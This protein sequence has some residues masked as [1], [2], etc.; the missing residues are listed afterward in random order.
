MA[1][2]IKRD[3]TLKSVRPERNGQFA[4][5]E[6]NKVLGVV[7]PW[8]AEAMRV[9]TNETLYVA[10]LMEMTPENLNR[11]ASAIATESVFGNALFMH[12]MEMERIFYQ[13]SVCELQGDQKEELQKLAEDMA[14]IVN[15]TVYTETQFCKMCEDFPL[16]AAARGIDEERLTKE[17]SEDGEY[18]ISCVDG[19]PI[20]RGDK[21]HTS[22]C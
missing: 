5:E 10:P 16:I 3:G 15:R 22:K 17:V 9:T 21:I 4:K 8:N 14:K 13:V 19:Q 20:F 1:L 2:L 7:A 6:I 11:N 18:M 12:D